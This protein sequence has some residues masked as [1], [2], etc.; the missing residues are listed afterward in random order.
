MQASH[1]PLS[2]ILSTARPIVIAALFR[3]FNNMDDAED[4]YQEACLRALKNWPTK[5]VPDNPVAWLVF[6]G[7]NVG[8]DQI[9]KTKN[10]TSYAILPE[11]ANISVDESEINLHNQIEIHPYHD[12]VLRLL[13]ICCHPSISFEQQVAL[14]LRIIIGMPV[15]EI[16]AAFLSKPASIAQRINR[17]K[18][19]IAKLAQSYEAP[20][21]AERQ[22]RIA[23]VRTA[24]YLL[25]NQG[26]AGNHAKQHINFLECR[27]AIRLARLLLQL[28]PNDTE[29]MGL[30]ALC[31]FQNSRHKARIDAHQAI[32]MLKDQNRKL[33]DKAQI[34]EALQI[35][36]KALRKG[37][38]G[39]FQIQASIAA[40]HAQSIDEA[41]TN[42]SEIIELYKI[43]SQI[44]PSPIISLNHA[45]AV[46]TSG[47]INQALKLA[48]PL[49]TTLN[50]YPYYHG[51]MAEI[52]TVLKNIPKAKNHLES[53]LKLTKNATQAILIREKIDQL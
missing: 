3:Y 18:A 38:V 52:Y 53:A 22:A 39:S 1:R 25:F 46:F 35:I 33:W 42:W 8:I 48:L 47:Q 36:E 34:V 2:D 49:K 32:I 15:E 27:E 17:A 4:A 13:F 7:R 51:L 21:A 50:D 29:N 5:T 41:S 37:S 19:S 11:N 16:A 45:A 6:V 31:L 28:A 12:D 26:Y 43:L 9:R 23:Q 24:I 30:L 40:T 10:T 14:C 44:A 20:N